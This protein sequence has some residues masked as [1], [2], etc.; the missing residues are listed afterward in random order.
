MRTIPKMHK[1]KRM[2]AGGSVLDFPVRKN[3]ILKI[4]AKYTMGLM[5]KMIIC[6]L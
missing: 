5:A 2:S 6:S 4:A 1:K 3:A